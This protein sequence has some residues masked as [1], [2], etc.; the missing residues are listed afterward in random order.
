MQFFNNRNQFKSVLTIFRFVKQNNLVLVFLALII[1]SSTVMSVL[2]NVTLGNEQ[3]LKNLIDVLMKYYRP[4]SNDPLCRDILIQ[5]I[6]KCNEPPIALL[7][8]PESG[9]TYVRGIIERLTG[10]FTGSVYED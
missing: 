9:N 5:F 1:P 7:S 8:Y 3:I 2:L 10:Y 4:W 6:P